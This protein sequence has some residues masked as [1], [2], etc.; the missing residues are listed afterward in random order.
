[1]CCFYIET[2]CFYFVCL[3]F[4]SFCLLRLSVSFIHSLLLSL[5][6]AVCFSND[7][8]VI[9]TCSPTLKFLLVAE[10]FWKLRERNLDLVS[11]FVYLYLCICI[12]VFVVGGKPREKCGRTPDFASSPSRRSV[13]WSLSS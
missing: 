10:G 12:C 5:F 7:S 9:C 4:V 2:V 8:N 11:V 3:S 6:A 1:M 13:P